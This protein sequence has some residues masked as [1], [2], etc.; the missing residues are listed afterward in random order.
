M[1]TNADWFTHTAADGAAIEVR[2]WLP[3]GD[4]RAVVLIAHGAA[5]HVGRYDRLAQ[6]LVDDGCAVYAPDQRAHGRTADRHGTLGVARPGGWQAMIDDLIAIADDLASRHAGT[7]LVLVGHSMGSMLSRHV[8]HRAGARFAG[9]ALSGMT[10]TVPADPDLLALLAA[11]EEGEGADAPSAIFSGMFDGFNDAFAADVAAPTGYE[12]LS[13][14]QDE[15]QIYADD[16]WCGIDLSNGFVTDMLGGAGE[17]AGAEAVDEIPGGRPILL[18]AGDDD[19]VGGNGAALPALA[20][21]LEA[22]GK[23]PVT[24]HHYA[25]GRHEMLNETNR[26]EVHGHIRAWLG[27]LLDG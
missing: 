18:I 8:M 27:A 21:A 5:E 26:D 20:A 4:V 6:L 17:L 16:P 22:A 7:P 2:R 24:A 25:G 14:D 9:F 1:T 10:E 12:W 11:V 3:E 13:R 23:G 19:P 15:V